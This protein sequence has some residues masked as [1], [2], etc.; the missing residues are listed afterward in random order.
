[1]EMEKVEKKALE[2]V[3]AAVAKNTLAVYLDFNKKL[4]IHTDASKYQLGSVISQGGHPN[5]LLLK[6]QDQIE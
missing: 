3:K 6:I 5:S 4:E 1:M 2:E